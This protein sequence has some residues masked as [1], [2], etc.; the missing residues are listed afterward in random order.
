MGAHTNCESVTRRD[1]IRLG[2]GALIG[3]G[4]IDA[5]RLRGL[6]SSGDGRGRAT[7]CILIWM[8]GG[9]SHYET[10]DPKPGAPSEIRGKFDPI[11]TKVPGISFS[12]HMTRLATVAAILLIVFCLQQNDVALPHSA[13]GWVGFVAAML[14]YAFAMIAFYVSIA[15]IGPTRTALLSYAEPI[16]SAGLGVAALGEALTLRQIGGITLMVGALAGATLLQRPA[17]I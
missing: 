13:K 6:A 16:V 2:L 8:D 17:S 9:P 10:F 4:L 3:G 14:F 5:L 11:A 7:R 1:S 12:Q 15:K